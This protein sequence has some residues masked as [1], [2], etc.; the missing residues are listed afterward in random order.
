MSTIRG[1][2][3][4]SRAPYALASLVVVNACAGCVADRLKTSRSSSLLMVDRLEAVAGD[5]SSTVVQ[6]DVWSTAAVDDDVVRASVRLQLKDSGSSANP[7]TPTPVNFVTIERYRVEYRRADGRREPGVDV[8]FPFDEAVTVTA[9]LEVVD[10]EFVLVRAS[11][12]LEPPLR[13]LANAGGA[14]IINTMAE[15]TFFGRDQ[16]GVAMHATGRI[17]VHFGDWPDRSGDGAHEEDAPA[18]STDQ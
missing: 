15:V 12:K 13:A 2:A 11:A 9:G 1:G 16:T 8:P 6:S 5:V 4:S 17:S 3:M 14:I 18:V 7:T 10:V